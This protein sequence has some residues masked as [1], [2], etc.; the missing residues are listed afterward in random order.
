MPMSCRWAAAM[1]PPISP[2]CWPRRCRPPSESRR[3]MAPRWAISRPAP[4]TVAVPQMGEDGD[5]YAVRVPRSMLTRIVQP[6]LEEIFGE[7]QTQAAG[8]RLRCR[9]RPPRGAD[10]R[11]LPARR[12]ARTGAARPQ[13]AGA[14]RPSADL[15]RAAGGIGGPDYATAMGLL[16]AGATMPPEAL[17]PDLA[18]GYCITGRPPAVSDLT[19]MQ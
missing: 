17:N 5:E 14:A 1:S 16:M 13:Q 8:Q 11:R 19:T 2:A 3:S 18:A 10:R 12:H 4:I 6:R 9:G 7:V 15:S